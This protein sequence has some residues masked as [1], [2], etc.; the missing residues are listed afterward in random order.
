MALDKNADLENLEEGESLLWTYQTKKGE[1]KEDGKVLRY[2][3]HRVLGWDGMLHIRGTFLADPTVWRTCF[4]YWFVAAVLAVVFYQLTK[5]STVYRVSDSHMDAMRTIAAYSTTLLGFM[6]SLFVSNVIKRWWTM[7]EKAVG[8]LWTAVTDT[9]Q[10]LAI[11]LTDPA[12]APFK[13]R[14]LRLGLLSHRLLYLEMGETVV[15]RRDVYIPVVER[16]GSGSL[17]GDAIRGEDVVHGGSE[18][19]DDLIE[20][21]LLT[22]AEKRELENQRRMAQLV[23]IW[24][25]RLG[26]DKLVERI[27]A[28]QVAGG[29]CG[30]TRTFDAIC[31]KAKV[32]VEDVFVYTQTQ[33]PF[34]YVHLL[35]FTV[36]MSNLLLAVKCGVA[37]GRGLAPPV[38]YVNPM[39]EAFQVLF[40][41]FSY[42]A[43]LRLCDDLS[44]PFG[45]S[46][47]GN[48]FPGYSYHCEMRDECLALIRAG[49]A[50]PK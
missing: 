40:V 11:R 34:Q 9:T 7:R 45:D 12:D 30:Q 17:L 16:H 32:A 41:P 19:L 33:L 47:N 39:V 49:A 50:P 10:F 20:V 46:L 36:M 25:N 24:I 1:P 35:A 29:V 5:R 21:G 44:N 14:I 23:W 31:L 8:G 6:L 48:N 18:T 15:K 27:E 42:H 4:V 38:E 26:R 13:E 43:F 3:V 37:I 2:N 28:K 22:E